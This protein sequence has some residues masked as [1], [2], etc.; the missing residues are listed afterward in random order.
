M[1]RIG[2][3]RPGLVGFI[4]KVVGIN[5]DFAGLKDSVV[6]S[7]SRFVGLIAKFAESLLDFAG[8]GIWPSDKT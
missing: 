7:F 5:L 8:L 3:I 2:G 4:K 6:G 1:L